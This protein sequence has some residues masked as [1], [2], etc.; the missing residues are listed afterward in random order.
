MTAFSAQVAQN[1]Y[2]AQGADLVHAVMSVTSGSATAAAPALAGARQSLVEALIVDCSG[3]M[4]GE[5]IIQTRQAVSKAIEL[6]HD[7][8]WFCVIAGTADAKVIV[9]LTQATPESRQSAEKT[10]RRLNASGG[11]AMSTWLRTA[12][13]ELGKKPGG[14]HHALLLTDGKD[15][16]EHESGSTPRW[17]SAKA[18]SNAMPAAWAPIGS[19]PSCGRSPP[20]CSARSTSFPAP[21]RSRPTSAR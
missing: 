6:L 21:I 15:Q 12:L 3:S 20:S 11:T 5:K 7:D 14:I 9:P 8:T 2:L 18:A 4:D 19:R 17:P 1:Q 16:S 10:V 13:A